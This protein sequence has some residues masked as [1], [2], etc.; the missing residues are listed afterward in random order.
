[1]SGFSVEASVRMRGAGPGLPLPRVGLIAAPDR[2]LQHDRDEHDDLQE[3][4]FPVSVD[5]ASPSGVERYAVVQTVSQRVISAGAALVLDS[6]SGEQP[7]QPRPKA[8]GWDPEDWG[9]RLPFNGWWVWA[10]FTG[11]FTG[12]ATFTATAPV[13]WGPGLRRAEVVLTLTVA[14]RRAWH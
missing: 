8:L 13:Q 14:G 12:P 10:D 2:S 5:F 6:A 11:D 9:S 3:W 7:W 1:M 4:P